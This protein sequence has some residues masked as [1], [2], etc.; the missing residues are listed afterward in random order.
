[1]HQ[2]HPSTTSVQLLGQEEVGTPGEGL[3]ITVDGVEVRTERQEEAIVEA[4]KKRQ[5]SPY[6]TVVVRT[7]ALLC[8]CCLSVGSHYAS[9][10]LA[11]LKSRLQ[12][13]LGAS[14]AEFSLLISAFSL[15]ST[16]T[17]LV[18]GV[19]ASTL[20]TTLTSILATSV[21]FLGQVLLLLGDIWGDVRL[22]VFGLWIFG[23][24]ISPLAVVQESIIVRFFRSH[25]LGVS[26]AF[27][28]L[29]GKGASFISALTSYPLTERYGSRAPFYAATTLAGLSV[30][31]NL[32][33]I[34][35]SKWLV[36]GAGAELEAVDI[37]D[38]AK[39]RL[40]SGM[41][42]TEAQALERVAEKRKVHLKSITKLG[43]VFWA[44]VGLN[45]VC[46]M[47]WHPFTHLA[48][49]IIEKRYGL[50][51]QDAANQASYLLAGPLLLYPACG[52]LVDRFQH[53]SIVIK[54]LLV[55]STLTMLAYIW[56]VLPAGWTASPKPAIALFASGHGFSP[57]L[58]VLLVPTIIPLKYVSTAL[59]VHKSL[60][61][62]GSTIFQTLAG[63]TLD[64]NKPPGKEG[65]V[66]AMQILLNMFLFLNVLQFISIAGMAYLQWRREQP[67]SE[68]S[69]LTPTNDE[70]MPLLGGLTVPTVPV[71]QMAQ[72]RA[73]VR[74]GR[75]FS[76][77]SYTLIL[78]A[79]V[80]FMGV[81]W[82][83]LGLKRGDH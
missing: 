70:N 27:G 31:V 16:W 14:H 33:Y 82:Y 63:L 24:G 60:E 46:G 74:R 30:V 76:I 55:S 22:M 62:T 18:G 54:L 34:A 26:M 50:E 38:E 43:D 12:R 20:G 81:A 28:L 68:L 29:A 39:A 1:M 41:A 64:I 42:L 37:S 49:N 56:L 75:I 52:F 5:S 40:R 4:L 72:S 53:R 78:I 19:L 21:I 2:R 59:G 35:A 11:P 3:S 48:A 44:Y 32:V 45:V 25:G 66:D 8:A 51:E 7:I 65:P 71:M 17:P 73:E 79:W 6:R 80:L 77:V 23:L 9:Y 57:L 47:I 61:Q 36:D 83:R 58:L 10:I 67:T 69:A 15:N 13:E